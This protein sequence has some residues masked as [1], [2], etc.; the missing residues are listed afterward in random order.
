MPWYP[1]DLIFVSNSNAMLKSFLIFSFSF[2]SFLAFGQAA[3]YWTESFGTRSMLLNG[4]VVG[5]VEDLGAVYYNPARLSQF[6]SPAFVISGQVYELN[7]I[8]IKNG[9]GDGLDLNESNFGGG[10]SL[11]SGT[12][13]LGFLEGHQFAYAFLSRSRSSN[14]FSFSVDEFG[15]F[16]KA[17]P[18][19]EYFSGE[20][21]SSNSRNDE[22]MGLSWSYPLS[23]NLSVGATGF[24]S[25]FNRASQARIQLQAYSLD[26]LQSGIYIEN[27]AYSYKSQSLLGKL[28]V[29]W[30]KDKYSIGLTIT[31]P[32]LQGIGSGNTKFETF[33]AGVDTTGNGQTDDIYI[34]D[35]QTDLD[36]IHKSPW[37]VAMGAG[38]RLGKRSILHLS[39]EWFAPIPEYTILQS[40]EFTG[41]STGQTLQI[42]VQDNLQSTINYG[43]G[44]EIFVNKNLS[45]FSSFATDF[46]PVDSDIRRLSEFT[47]A[48]NDNTF[49]ADIFHFGFG[50]DFRTK[51]ADLTIGATYAT[52]KEDVKRN[53]TIDDGQDPV[54]TDAQ[55]LYSRWRFL[56][57]FEFHFL[58]GVKD[59]FEVKEN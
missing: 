45:F 10:P 47:S 15:D 38:I 23:E 18:G 14:S 31:T 32:K 46:A 26:S 53:F 11:V 21:L 56:I 40:N 34:I 17:F 43:L 44:L 51:F 1:P 9:L 8:T 55:I 2:I 52:S 16:V 5:S 59:K 12:F 48:I 37:S 36:V 29:S 35:N 39:T 33:L 42:V 4:V 6:E 19:D 20:V 58:D 25:N 50:T 7:S 41:Q 3:H 49:K 28:G 54:T 24:Y 27:R 22:W 30:A 57:G 13:K